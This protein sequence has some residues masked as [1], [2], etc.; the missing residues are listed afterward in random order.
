V[1][2]FLVCLP[3]QRISLFDLVVPIDNILF[4]LLFLSTFSSFFS[5]DLLLPYQVFL[6]SL[7]SGQLLFLMKSQ[8]GVVHLFVVLVRLDEPILVEVTNLTPLGDDITAVAMAARGYLA[9]E[10]VTIFPILVV[11][12]HQLCFVV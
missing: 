2:L 9:E 3:L 5:L 10:V 8:E 6:L 12:L 7:F 1:N 4:V 11:V